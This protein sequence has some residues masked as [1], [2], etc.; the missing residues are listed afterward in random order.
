[1]MLH[2]F[3]SNDS[4]LKLAADVPLTAEEMAWASRTKVM[5]ANKEKKKAYQERTLKD[6]ESLKRRRKYQGE[7]KADREA[8]LKKQAE[9]SAQA[10]AAKKARLVEEEEAAAGGEQAPMVLS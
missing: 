8:R 9:R 4:A 7:D 1:M 6:W 10:R 3:D 5:R 2:V